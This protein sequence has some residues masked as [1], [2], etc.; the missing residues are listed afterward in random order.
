M[1]PKITREDREDL[2]DVLGLKNE[3]VQAKSK[4]EV[5]T[6]LYNEQLEMLCREEIDAELYRALVLESP[7]DKQLL[8]LKGETDELLKRKKK[9]VEI[10]I[11]RLMAEGEKEGEDKDE[12]KN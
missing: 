2:L 8:L 11:R 1:A 9:V 5:W 3:P 10:I 7:A 4:K 6:K 12:P